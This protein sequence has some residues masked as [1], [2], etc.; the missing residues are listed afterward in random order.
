MECENL[1]NVYSFIDWLPDS[2]QMS[3]HLNASEVSATLLTNSTAIVSSLKDQLERFGKMLNRKA[4]IQHYTAEG[5]ELGDFQEA[6]E[7]ISSVISEYQQVHN[8]E[9]LEFEMMEE[10][11]RLDLNLASDTETF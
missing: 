5:L 1:K 2:F 9:S 8:S 11:Q 6:A 3:H 4:F 10:E 7:T